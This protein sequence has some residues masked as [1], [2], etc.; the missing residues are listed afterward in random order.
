MGIVR[1]KTE[2]INELVFALIVVVFIPIAQFF[3]IYLPRTHK[4]D[5][6]V[7]LAWLLTRTN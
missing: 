5:I 4:L 1:P 2:G 7:H 6:A 3:R